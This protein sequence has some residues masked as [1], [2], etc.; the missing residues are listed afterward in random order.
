MKKYLFILPIMASCNGSGQYNVNPTGEGQSNREPVA[1]N[2]KLESLDKDGNF[3][4]DPVLVCFDVDGTILDRNDSLIDHEGL[5]NLINNLLES[6]NR[7]A[8]TTLSSRYDKTLLKKI[9]LT[10][11]QIKDIPIM[12]WSDPKTTGGGHKEG[13]I[14]QAMKLTNIKDIKRV[15]LV[16]DDGRQIMRA[17]FFGATGV[18]AGYKG[19]SWSKVQESVDKLN[20]K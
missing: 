14:Q 5:K 10:E 18:P 11:D 12:G 1:R 7:V 20:Q 8:I 17:K 15:I 13:H 6:G 16:D 3:K 4:E 19:F 9:G 2:I